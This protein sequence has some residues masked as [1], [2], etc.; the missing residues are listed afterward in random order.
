MAARR[1]AR[2]FDRVFDPLGLTNGQFPL[3]EEHLSRKNPRL[4]ALAVSLAMDQ[5][6]LTAAVTALETRG[7]VARQADPDDLRARRVAMTGAGVGVI[8]RAVPLWQAEIAAV[9]ASHDP[10][11]AAGVLVLMRLS[12]VP[13]TAAA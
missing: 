4:E 3:K 5:A 7:L 11:R 13:A 12:G 10:D 9:R 8:S 6:T 1:F 2:L